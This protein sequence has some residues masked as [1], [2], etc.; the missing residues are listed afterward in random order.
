MVY[1]DSENKSISSNKMT[2]DNNLSIF[3]IL[4]SI[5]KIEDKDKKVQALKKMLHV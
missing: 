4:N 2:K 1:V 5:D 3:D